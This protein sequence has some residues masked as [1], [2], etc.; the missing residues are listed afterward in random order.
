MDKTLR[1]KIMQDI[2][3]EIDGYYVYGPLNFKGYLSEHHLLKIV[4][5]LKELND[6]W[7]RQINEYF[8]QK[9]LEA[10]SPQEDGTIN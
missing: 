3:Q 9:E 1:D 10:N 4:E 5:I 8:K 2:Y 6:P 7:D